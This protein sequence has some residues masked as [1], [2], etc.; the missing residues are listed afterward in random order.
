[1][2]ADPKIIDALV[3]AASSLAYARRQDMDT[4]EEWDDLE[5][6]VLATEEAAPSETSPRY[7]F[8]GDELMRFSTLASGAPE[9][10]A[11]DVEDIEQVAYAIEA[12]RGEWFVVDEIASESNRDWITAM[13][14]VEFLKRGG[15]VR[16]D[17]TAS[18]LRAAE[19]FTPEQAI[20]EFAIGQIRAREESTGR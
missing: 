14:A 16:D 8:R 6:A 9:D 18:R 2:N 15:L 12:K 5:R 3:S 19:G 10:H 17:G 1:M 13:I 20:A 7:E 11:C 4:C